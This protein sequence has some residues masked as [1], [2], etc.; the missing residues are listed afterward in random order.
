M[1]ERPC[2]K[3]P[4][5]T[6]VKLQTFISPSAHNICAVC[7]ED[8]SSKFKSLAD[9]RI[10]ISGGRRA[11][12]NVKSMLQSYLG[13]HISETEDLPYVCKNCF[14]AVS[15]A[16]KTAN[17]NKERFLKVR[18]EIRGK[19]MRTKAKRCCSNPDDH[20]KKRWKQ[21]L[22]FQFESRASSKPQIDENSDDYWTAF[23]RENDVI[24]RKESQAMSMKVLWRS[25]VIL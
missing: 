1:A 13:E 2:K 6:P 5:V 15:N 23:L 14:R 17:K 8:I 21:S 16:S 4:P 3:T 20:A 9:G 19:Y 12:S 22:Q 7:S 11:G 18:E 24:H 25:G 10:Q